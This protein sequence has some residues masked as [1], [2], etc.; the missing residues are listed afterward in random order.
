MYSAALI[1]A[2]AS[3]SEHLS[4][5]LHPGS[6]VALLTSNETHAIEARQAGFEVRDTLLLLWPGAASFAFLLRAPCQGGTTEQVGLTSTGVLHVDACRVAADLSEF[7]SATGKPRSGMGHAKGYGMGEG[8]GGDKAN[9]PHVDGRW[10]SN[11]CF[12]HGPRC[13]RV[14]EKRV[15]GH[16]GYPRG[17]GGSSS[18]FS[19]K[20]TATTRTAAW[21]GHADAEGKETVAVWEC[22]DDCAA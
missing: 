1:A 10:P 5:K 16:K 9:P 4:E 7:F 21:V 17:P 12:I 14:G 3:W 15:E 2:R 8:Y 20:G 6:Y 22:Q 19:Q 11:A 18:Q 13:R